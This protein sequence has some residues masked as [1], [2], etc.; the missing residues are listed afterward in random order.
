MKKLIK[1]IKKW[2]AHKLGVDAID[3]IPT[4]KFTVINKP[5]VANIS[6]D[7]AIPNEALEMLSELSEADYYNF[8]KFEI[9]KS[10]GDFAVKVLPELMSYTIETRGS[11]QIIRC[12]L[13]V[14]PP[15]DKA[16][17]AELLTKQK[18]EE[19]KK[20]EEFHNED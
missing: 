5:L 17:L 20:Y 6:L 8:V 9:K 18:I 15:I 2:L 12:R 13:D 7:I 16:P 3:E 11:N 1:K 14:V 10:V 19:D 4:Q